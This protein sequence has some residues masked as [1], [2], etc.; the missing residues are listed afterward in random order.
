MRTSR[1]AALLLALLVAVACAGGQG[2]TTPTTPAVPVPPPA[3]V[4][5]TTPAAQVAWLWLGTRPGVVGIDPAGRIAG[6]VADAPNPYLT[7][8]APDGA[9][10]F[11][12]SGAG[13]A[14]HDAATGQVVRT[15]GRPTA[16]QVLDDSFSPD[17]RY[18]ALLTGRLSAGMITTADASYGVE[19]LDL[20]S[21]AAL[22]R[23]DLGSVAHGGM[24][25]LRFGPDGR[26][27]A[28]TG[29]G[30]VQRLSVV[31]VGAG[32]VSV[33][34]QAVA[35]RDGR[36][37]PSCADPAP[38]AARFLPDGRTI[39]AFCHVDGSVWFVDLGR[40]SVT[41]QIPAQANNPFWDEPIFAP[42]GRTLYLHDVFSET[43]TTIDLARRA[44]LA[45]A[46]VPHAVA[47]RGLLDWLGVTTAEAGG[48]ATTVP[49]SP[50]GSR[51]YLARPD[52]V[53]VI[54]LP[55]LHPMATLLPGQRSGEVWVSGD[56][57]TLFVLNGGGSRVDVLRADGKR[58]ASVPLDGPAGGFVASAHG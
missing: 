30:G 43:L 4:A 15:L 12:L 18:L 46:P 48:I 19:V 8:R 47:A 38:P 57:Q 11:L 21:G 33:V 28:F 55:D 27:Y 2:P 14:V 50:D 37:L 35:G 24:G 58:V 45:T 23:L 40:L 52:G 53:A 36:R 26:L 6:S 22:P 34:A 1:T 5:S 16:D 3:A 29:T 7:V 56:G 17:G 49:V 54:R 39:A 31:T 25:W 32:A 42:D 13:V 44:V 9:S 51:M 20:R 41:G 10:F